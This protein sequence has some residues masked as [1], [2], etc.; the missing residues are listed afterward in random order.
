MGTRAE[1]RGQTVETRAG[2]R[3]GRG[4]GQGA[5][6]GDK[7]QGQRAEGGGREKRVGTRAGIES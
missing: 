6:D 5:E 1:N 4:W 2:D 7:G 3:E